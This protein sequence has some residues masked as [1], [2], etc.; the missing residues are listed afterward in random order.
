N[1]FIMHGLHVIHGD[2]SDAQNRCLCIN[3]IKM[4]YFTSTHF[5]RTGPAGDRE[6]KTERLIEGMNHF[7][8]SH[9]AL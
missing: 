5:L 4:T 9:L 8:R 7:L 2:V 1:M 6:S 3:S